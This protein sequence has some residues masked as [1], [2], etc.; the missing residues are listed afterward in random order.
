MGTRILVPWWGPKSEHMLWSLNCK[1]IIVKWKW[2]TTYVRIDWLIYYWNKVINIRLFPFQSPWLHLW[3][4][5]DKSGK[6]E[7]LEHYFLSSN[8]KIWKDG[9]LFMHEHLSLISR[10]PK[11]S[12]RVGHVGG[13]TLDPVPRNLGSKNTL[14]YYSRLNPCLIFDFSTWVEYLF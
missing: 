3:C 7:L 12:V 11:L 9:Q 14:N 8:G 5:V 13:F 10:H 6:V 2:T 1:I 4:K